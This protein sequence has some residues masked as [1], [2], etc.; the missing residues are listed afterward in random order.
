MMNRFATAVLLICSASCVT[1]TP[2]A[3][4]PP[5]SAPSSVAHR[6]PADFTPNL[7]RGI[8]QA[9]SLIAASVGKLYPGAVFLV[10]RYGM[11]YEDR[12]FGYA[13][14]NDY[15][16]R[17]LASPPPM[18]RETM[19]D[20]ASVTKV[21]GT[22]MGVMRLVDEG[23][24]DLDAPV[25]RY[26]PDFRDVHKD[27]IT[28]RHLLNHSAGLVQWQPLYYH[29]ASEREAYRVIRDMPLQWGVGA[30]RHY[31]DFSFMLLGYI[32]ERVSGQRLDVFLD[33]TIYRPLGLDSTTFVPRRHGFTKFAVTEQGNV[34]ERHMVYDSTFGYR[35]PGDPTVWNGWRHHV[36]DGEVDDGNSFYAHGGIAGHA[37]LF[38]TAGQL[39]VL[40]DMLV[41]GGAART[42]ILNADVIHR[43]LTRD[44]YDNYLG[45]MRSPS[46]PE[47]SFYHS[48]FTG[49]YVLGVPKF[50]LSVILLTNRQNMG[51]DAKG[52][53]P[54]LAPLQ[55][56]VAK[57]LVSGAEA[58]DR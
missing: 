9:D 31:S 50:G 34:Y 13:Q 30:G 55:D 45:W 10:S 46:L 40:M 43:F 2:A 22:T 20:L 5:A 19:F 38:S 8:R 3:A 29:A 16:G 51:T 58:D 52:Y 47:G 37:G 26:L 33:S 56:A 14:L 39:R 4:P 6:K 23:R 44:R 7:G 54:N 49:T 53:F 21:M 18:T 12:A 28:V 36:L 48:G 41:N 1:T 42:R 35:Y 11:L 57:A 27:S 15:E 25:Y 17:P 24:V 32:L